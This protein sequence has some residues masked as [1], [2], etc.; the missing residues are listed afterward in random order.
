MA[1]KQRAKDTSRKPALAVAPTAK[2]VPAWLD[3]I[4][5][6]FPEDSGR[7]I[8]LTR[9]VEAVI[10]MTNALPSRAIEKT[11]AASTNLLVLLTAL[12]SPEILPELER[13]EPL[14]SPYLKGLQEQ[15]ELLRQAG[16]LMSADQVGVVLGVTRQAI[17][18]RRVAGKLIAI[19]QGQR[20]F[21]YPACQFTSRGSV[22][23]LDRMLLALGRSDAW[24]QLIFLLSPNSVLG[25]RSPLE[26]LSE[27][28]VGVVTSAA[29]VFG[30]QGSL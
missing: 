22:P 2:E 3:R 13:H 14:A 4:Q 16:G 24:M 5:S 9:A 11:A 29:S 15:Q 30:E 1:N 18:K 7:K 12:Q 20:G 28:Q 8:F 17:D 23:G 19:P 10:E 26:L 25:N 6:S 27:G 21:G